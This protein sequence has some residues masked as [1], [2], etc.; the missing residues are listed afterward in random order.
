MVNQTKLEAIVNHINHY[1]FEGFSDW[2]IA[3]QLYLST[4]S[5]E[6]I[7][8][9][10]KYAIHAAVKRGATSK[11]GVANKLRLNSPT[12]YLFFEYFGA[13]LKDFQT[14]ELP[15]MSPRELIDRY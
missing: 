10:L 4:E 11:K 13:S 3:R 2:A 5:F 1:R 7:D 15:N 6:A 8:E 14:Q 12:I 9:A